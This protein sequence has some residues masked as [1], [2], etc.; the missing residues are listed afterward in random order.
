MVRPESVRTEGTPL[1]TTNRKPS[2][3]IALR[4]L[5]GCERGL[6][7]LDAIAK[8]VAPNEGFKPAQALFLVRCLRQ[9][10]EKPGSV[11]LRR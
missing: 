4:I 6:E 11:F 7:K 5:R 9:E 1:G 8:R 2:E 3:A 10:I